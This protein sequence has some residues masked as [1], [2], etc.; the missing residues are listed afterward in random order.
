MTF[1][2]IPDHSIIGFDTETRDPGLKEEGPGWARGYGNIV[3]VS[4]A[5]GVDSYY[6]PLRHTVEPQDNV[7]LEPTLK[8]LKDILENPTI[9]KVGAN[10]QYDIG[11]IA[12]EGINVR[13]PLIDVLAIEHILYPGPIK[14]YSLDQLAKKYLGLSKEKDGIQEWGD[15]HYKGYKDQRANL[16]RIP[17]RIVAPYA[18]TDA[19]LPLRIYNCQYPILDSAGLLDIFTMEMKLIYIL[20]KMRQRGMPVDLI[21]AQEAREDLIYIEKFLRKEL[22]DK[23]GYRI[24]VNSSQ[25]IAPVFDKLEIEYPR[26][27]KG[28]PSFTGPWLEDQ[29][30]PIAKLIVEIRKISKAR[31]DFIEN[32]I[33]E[34]AINSKIYPLLDPLLPITGRFSCSQ[35]NGQQI[36]ARNADTA[37]LIRGIF[38]PEKGY[39][40]WCKMDY[41]QIEYRMFA[42]FAYELLGD[43]YLY[44]AY[45]NPHTDFHE[46]VINMLGLDSSFRKPVKNI[47]F[48]KLYGGGYK[49][50]AAMLHEVGVTIKPS[51]FIKLYDEKFPQANAL[52]DAIIN[53]IHI[54]G[55]TRTIMNRRVLFDKWTKINTYG[56]VGLPKAAAVAKWGINEIERAN[57]Y[58]GINYILQGS[59]ADLIKAA[60]VAAWEAGYF[61]KVG[62]P[63][64]TVH[65][66]LNF[67][68][69]PDLKKDF[70]EMKQILETPIKL[71]VPVIMDAEIG[72]DW[73]HCN[74][75]I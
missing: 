7:E 56:E 5:I 24:N 48:M 52:T 67:S 61:D 10:L 63:H 64:I 45:K 66:E 9:A 26:T 50:T 32:A 40:H 18:K 36:P 70:I 60:M 68:Y 30:H 14:R 33:I 13:G 74:E 3:G 71:S 62:Y 72:P 4:I 34:K 51:E 58:K 35:P 53:D 43:K 22:E 19:L 2:I 41:A 6:Y 49:K 12:E 17:P 44:E 57:T 38:I 20:V 59:A 46:T 37:P 75:A 21:K 31:N 69:H 42:H 25:Q 23:V 39:T 15:K 1:P 27:E 47:N 11:W 65:D 8:F 55:E 28:N 54:T 16:Y 29:N 73:G